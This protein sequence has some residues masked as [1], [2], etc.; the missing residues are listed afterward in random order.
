MSASW[1]SFECF[2]H[3][4]T[5]RPAIRSDSGLVFEVRIEDAGNEPRLT[6]AGCP[7]CGEPCELRDWWTATTS[8]HGS[9]AAWEPAVFSEMNE[10]L[11]RIADV[12]EKGG[13]P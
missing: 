4:N 3:Q 11:G 9:S 1:Y 2:K 6:V 12:L 5:T 10:R 7:V 8:G 13:R